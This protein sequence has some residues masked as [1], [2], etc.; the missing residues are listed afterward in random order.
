MLKGFPP[1]RQAGVCLHITALPGDLGIG[2]LGGAAFAFVDAL[3]DMELRVW[4]IL[5]TGPTGFGNSPYQALSSFAGNELLIDI[6]S[7]VQQGLLRTEEVDELRRL[8]SGYVDFNR[9]APAKTRLLDVAAERFRHRGESSAAVQYREFIDAHD[10][11]WLG[12]YALY[13]ALKQHHNSRSWT[14]WPQEYRER[15]SEAV[16]SFERVS[17]DELTRIKIQQ[18]FF[19]SQWQRLKQYAGE[20]GVLLFGDTPI[21]VA[22]DSA[23]V[24]AEPK[25]VRLDPDNNPVEVGGVPPDGFSDDGQL[26]GNPI[27][28]WEHHLKTD[29][30][31]WRKRLNFTY[32]MVDLLRID[33]FRGLH[34]YWA[35]PFGEATARSGC[36]RTAPGYELLTAVF[37]D[38]N[39]PAMI[40]EDLGYMNDKVH[41]LRDH[42]RIP[43]LVFLQDLFRDDSFDPDCV[44]PHSV[45][46][47]ST[48]DSDTIVGWFCGQ[49][50][51]ETSEA[52]MRLQQAVLKATGGSADRV[53]EDFV[54]LALA[55]HSNL[56]IVQLQDFLGL[57]SEA[58]FNTPGTVGCNWHWRVT[59]DRMN[60]Q[61]IDY[62][63]GMVQDSHRQRQAW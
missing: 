60:S 7:L 45:C 55:S 59:E 9:L 49:V 11:A 48:H 23:D 32:G 36:W 42:F 30:I 63:K 4:Q 46:Y 17:A 58:R 6:S 2:E 29:F 53:A 56:T 62:V 41:A 61:T 16:S 12:D 39:E 14:E 33:H 38:L 8:P 10:T 31:W 13:R 26:W 19:F 22:L 47:P 28:D 3:A 52:Q 18:F 43:G 20:K 34:A 37:R 25:L 54:R 44:S 40:A 51:A 5:P 21:Y 15:D 27:Y 24:W 35:I 50:E 1:V 57:G